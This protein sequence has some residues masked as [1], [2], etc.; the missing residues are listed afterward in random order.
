MAARETKAQESK[1]QESP[2]DD[3]IAQAE[4]RIAEL[5]A[6]AEKKF[7]EAEKMLAVAE[8]ATGKIALTEEQKRINAEG[9]EYV[10]VKL[11]KD[12]GKYADDVF[13]AV[14]GEGCNIPRG[15]PVKIKKKFAEVLDQSDL[16]DMKTAEFMDAEAEKF[17]QQSK[18]LNI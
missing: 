17:A 14:N 8:K 18:A 15:K 11:F 13:V 12:S 3:A 2:K 9:E 4:A 5:L 6:A 10:T 1:V 16:Q 7:E